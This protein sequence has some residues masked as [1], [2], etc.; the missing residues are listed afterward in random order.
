MTVDCVMKLVLDRREEFVAC[1]GFGI[2]VDAGRKYV[3][4]FAIENLFAAANVANAIEQFVKIGGTSLLESFVVEREPFD[5]VFAK[6]LG[7]PLAKM[8]T[9]GI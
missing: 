4:N 7:R 2:V 5:Y 8:S 6:P 3:A 9:R 1:I